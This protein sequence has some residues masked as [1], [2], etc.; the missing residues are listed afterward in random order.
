ML[1]LSL[2]KFRNFFML[3]IPENYI[4]FITY[5]EN[6]NLFLNKIHK[7]Y[8]TCLYTQLFLFIDHITI[9]V[10][11]GSKM[12]GQNYPNK[13]L[14]MLFYDDKIYIKSNIKIYF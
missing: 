9:S 13:N 1:A 14:M 4:N 2:I 11:I 3:Y 10:D 7:F 6:E 5:K 8:Q 12:G